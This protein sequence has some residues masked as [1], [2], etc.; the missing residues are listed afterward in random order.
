MDWKLQ[1]R[2]ALEQPEGVRFD[3]IGNEGQFIERGKVLE[4]TFIRAS[5]AWDGSVQ[6]PVNS[7][8]VYGKD[9]KVPVVLV[10]R[11]STNL[12][13]QS[14]APVARTIS[15][16]G[17]CT[18]SMSGDGYVSIVS[19]SVR[20]AASDG[21]PATFVAGGS[22]TI[23]PHGDVTWAQLERSDY[24]SSHIPTAASAV[25]RADEIWTAQVATNRVMHLAALMH[26][27][28]SA[29]RPWL[30]A[31]GLLISQERQELVITVGGVRFAAYVAQG[32]VVLSLVST[33][34]TTRVEVNGETLGF[35]PEP[36]Y[37]GEP[38]V[39]G[40]DTFL[41]LGAERLG[42]PFASEQLWPITDLPGSHRQW[43]EQLEDLGLHKDAAVLGTNM[44]SSAGPLYVATW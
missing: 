20:T 39:F 14:N 29:P 4:S 31:P 34:A 28:R 32:W 8:R 15:V 36:I 18:V 3:V 24:A 26:P 37:P 10:E 23:T 38:I 13:L 27:G 16:T 1:V 17:E 25:T 21:L 7:M 35:I 42:L 30:T 43:L 33:D 2:G 19:G 11:G 22:V 6:Q 12:F 9:S 41:G 40:G 44:A 5:P